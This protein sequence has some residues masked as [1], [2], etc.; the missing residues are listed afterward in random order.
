[1]YGLLV[2][3]QL[4]SS[5]CSGKWK[6]CTRSH[7]RN[8]IF[9]TDCFSFCALDTSD[10]SFL[11]SPDGQ[12]GRN[13]IKNSFCFLWSGVKANFG[14]KSGKAC[15]ECKVCLLLKKVTNGNSLSVSQSKCSC[16]PP[17]PPPPNF[18]VSCPTSDRM[19]QQILQI[20]FKISFGA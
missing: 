18:E 1:M 3:E 4:C 19:F 2:M 7:E 17:P 10:L 11:V 12:S 16:M 13:L 5:V 15:Y 14:V 8:L 6:S 9:S 20:S